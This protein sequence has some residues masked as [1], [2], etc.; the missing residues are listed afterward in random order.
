M[1]GDDQGLC[2]ICTGELYALGFLGHAAV[3][4][5]RNCGMEFIVTDEPDEEDATKLREEWERAHRGPT[6]T[7]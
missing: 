4:R 6:K 3:I 5:C 7:P 1:A 2:P